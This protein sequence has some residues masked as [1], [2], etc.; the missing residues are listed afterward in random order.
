MFSTRLTCAGRT[1]S[2]IVRSLQ[3]DGWE[4]TIEEDSRLLRRVR[5]TDW[6]RVERAL[7]A[8]DRDIRALTE[9]GWRVT[10]EARGTVAQSTNR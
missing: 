3:A 8:I 1:R 7:A 10:S 4:M 9:L 2:F 5:Y 6:H